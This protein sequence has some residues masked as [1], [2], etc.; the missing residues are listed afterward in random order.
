VPEEILGQAGTPGDPRGFVVDDSMDVGE[1]VRR[2]VGE[3]AVLE[4]GPDL[5]LRIQFRRIR[6]TTRP[7]ASGGG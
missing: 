4:I 3:P 7:R 6:G 2:E 1:I 5:F